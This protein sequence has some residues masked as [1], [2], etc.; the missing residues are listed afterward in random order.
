MKPGDKF[1]VTLEGHAVAEAVV[2]SLDEETV[3]LVLPATRFTMGRATSLTD[4]PEREVEVDRVLLDDIDTPE[5][6]VPVSAVAS[7]NIETVATND[8]V[9]EGIRDAKLDSSALD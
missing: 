5:P 7:G 1:A 3:T 4:L 2:E 8:A 6:V 9:G